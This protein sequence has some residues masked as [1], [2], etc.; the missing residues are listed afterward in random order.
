MA[1]G[2]GLE[3]PAPPGFLEAVGVTAA[4]RADLEAYR[5]LLEEANASLNLVGR[6]TLAE[7]WTRHVLDSAQ[8][9][10][11]A[12]RALT[13]ADIGSGAGLPGIVI[14]ILLKGRAGAQVHLI[15]SVA[16]KCA[17]LAR[18]VAALQLPAQVR[19]ARA[20]DLD[21]KV[22]VVT[23]RAVAPLP[24]LLGYAQPMMKKGAMGLFLKGAG[25][26]TEV[27]EARTLWRFACTITDSLSDPRGRILAV[28]ELAR[29]ARR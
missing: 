14:A 19:H 23:A 2:L 29:A 3:F 18:V 1:E 22:E 8:L 26:D 12:P 27:M 24:R 13:W 17:F 9:R 5:R 4:A 20:E 7:F 11:L 6:S 25:V 16:K 15:E 21:L 28:T 10:G